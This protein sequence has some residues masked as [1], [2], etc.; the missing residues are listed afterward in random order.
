MIAW[1]S[2]YDACRTHFVCDEV[3]FKSSSNARGP[4]SGTHAESSNPR[5]QAKQARLH[6]L[7]GLAACHRVERDHL[8]QAHDLE[9]R[10]R[11]HAARRGEVRARLLERAHRFSDAVDGCDARYE[12]EDCGSPCKKAEKY[13]R[14]PGYSLMIFAPRASASWHVKEGVRPPEMT[15]TRTCA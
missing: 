1:D 8:V 4:P 15:L 13:D 11:V 7:E 3:L 5:S 10:L 6:E 2:T 14:G 9:E 12:R